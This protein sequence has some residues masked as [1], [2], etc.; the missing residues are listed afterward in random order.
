L[1]RSMAES[2]SA[3]DDVKGPRPA[4]QV[5]ERTF[6]ILE[7]FTEARPEWSTT[8]IARELDLPVPTV[9]RIL[10]ALKR[11]GYV[12]QHEETRRFRLGLAALS[13]GERARG[14]ADLRPAAV[15]PLRQLSEATGETAL[16]TVLSPARDR[17]VCLER[18]ES[19]RP[20]RLSV[21]PGRQLPLH[22]GASQKALLAFMP[23]D[24]IDRLTAQPL[25]R[26]CTATI[27]S[28]SALRHELTAI[29]ARGWSSSY[30]ETDI[31]VWGVA[32]PVL[33]S[34]DVV[35]AVGIAGPSPRL[36]V[37][38]VRRDVQL[39]HEAATVIG[40]A[41]GFSTPPVT[42]SEARI[43]TGPM[44]RPAPRATRAAAGPREGTPR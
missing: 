3:A 31:G 1:S 7:V 2:P 37:E 10:A 33:S 22:A 17:S 12:S 18:V 36:T 27:T 32:V 28:R 15:G 14:L 5:L 38:R 4:F 11:L 9:H 29:R 42:V 6:G 39:I 40:R 13:L 41:L 23:A 21:Q 26:L 16:L 19:S 44:D 30:E 34:A 8:G 24:E 25:E 20:L 43:D 35:C